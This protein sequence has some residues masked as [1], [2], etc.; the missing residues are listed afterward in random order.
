MP[1]RDFLGL[2]LACDIASERSAGARRSKLKA[3]FP[4]TC[5]SSVWFFSQPP[6]WPGDMGSQQCSRGASPG[7]SPKMAPMPSRSEDPDPLS[8]STGPGNTRG[9]APG[10]QPLSAPGAP[11]TAPHE[12]EGSGGAALLFLGL[13]FWS[14]KNFGFG[15]GNFSGLGTAAAVPP[16]SY[17]SPLPSMSEAPVLRPAPPDPRSL[18]QVTT[19]P[20]VAAAGARRPAPPPTWR[21]PCSR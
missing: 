11:L 3:P 14:R 10:A 18:P 12:P 7:S 5:L 2:E 19:R 9:N 15:H 16:P 20:T 4:R 1:H 13:C 6:F 8:V 17:S 21:T